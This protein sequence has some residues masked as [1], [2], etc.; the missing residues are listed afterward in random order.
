LAKEIDQLR[1]VDV[2]LASSGSLSGTEVSAGVGA[3]PHP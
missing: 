2:D 3:P 1:A